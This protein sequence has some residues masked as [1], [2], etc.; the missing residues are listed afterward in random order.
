MVWGRAPSPAQ[1]PPPQLRVPHASRLLRD[2]IPRPHPSEDFGQRHDRE[3][4]D[5]TRAASPHTSVEN[6]RMQH[7]G[8]AALKRRV[9]HPQ[10]GPG[11]SPHGVPDVSRL[12]RDMG[13]HGPIPLRIWAAPRPGMARLQSCHANSPGNANFRP[14]KATLH[15]RSRR[16]P[17]DSHLQTCA[18]L[19]HPPTNTS[20]RHKGN[21]P[22]E[23]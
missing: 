2:G 14:T 4:H 20:G 19:P 8:R 21:C 3:R 5:F 16:S 13:F 17:K 22:R 12:L 7:R 15:R 10:R 11:F 1:P 23:G 9:K 6:R 18:S